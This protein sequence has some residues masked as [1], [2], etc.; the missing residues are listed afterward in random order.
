MGIEYR[1]GRDGQREFTDRKVRGSN[2]I[3]AS[4]LLLSRL[5]QPGNILALV[6]SSGGMAAVH[7]KGAKVERFFYRIPFVWLRSVLPSFKE[8]ITTKSIRHTKTR[9]KDANSTQVDDQEICG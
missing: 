2:P 1:W 3:S 9:V 8:M 5:G 6:P 7:R 4:R